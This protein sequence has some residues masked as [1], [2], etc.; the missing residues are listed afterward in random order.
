MH[1]FLAACKPPGVSS[2]RF[3]SR[4][5]AALPKGTRVGH[6][7]TLDPL[8]AGLLVAAVGC[9]TRFIEHLPDSKCYEV[10][11]AFGTETDTLDREGEVVRTEPLPEDLRERVEQALPE[12][13]GNVSQKAPKYSAL[14]HEG[15]R[16]HEL[17]RSGRGDRVPERTRQVRIDSVGSPRWLG[18][19]RIVIDVSC[20]K[21]AYMRSLAAELGERAGCCAH[22][23]GLLR[24]ECNGFA[25]ADAIPEGLLGEGGAVV[26]ELLRPVNDA[27]AHVR[28]VSLD[29]KG[30]RRIALGQR[31]PAPEGEEDGTVRI[32]DAG[33]SLLGTGEVGG[34]FLRPRK[35]LPAEARREAVAA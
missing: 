23:S 10:E 1:G 30:S 3:L 22:M 35:M 17:M 25:L 6:T 26:P 5:K 2:A 11:V 32:L 33:G 31:Q 15:R 21:G 20:G 13:V 19:D 7:G 16:M 34:G 8:A 9:A 12:M 29:R 24:T 14:K 18:D 28:A 27:L 4:V